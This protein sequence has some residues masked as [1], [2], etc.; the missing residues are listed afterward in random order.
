MSS[1]R[2][3]NN[4]ASK[5]SYEKALENKYAIEYEH[6]MVKQHRLIPNSEVW[7]WSNIPEDY[8]YDAG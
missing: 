7:H 3:R 4:I 1:L 5:K 2:E 8:L 6:E